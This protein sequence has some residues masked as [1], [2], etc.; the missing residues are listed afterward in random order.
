MK[1]FQ[2]CDDYGHYGQT[3]EG[4]TYWQR[5]GTTCTGG[6]EAAVFLLLLALAVGLAIVIWKAWPSS[7]EAGGKE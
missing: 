1:L 6:I 7:T 3:A 4:L 5:D 2:E